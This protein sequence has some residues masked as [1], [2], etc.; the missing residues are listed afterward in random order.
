MYHSQRQA[1]AR[2]MRMGL[3][4][5]LVIHGVGSPEPYQQEQEDEPNPTTIDNILRQLNFGGEA[6]GGENR[7]RGT[8]GSGAVADGP[9]TPEPENQ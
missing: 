2:R 3:S 7:S 9:E 4:V 5:P 1:V 8:G 6:A